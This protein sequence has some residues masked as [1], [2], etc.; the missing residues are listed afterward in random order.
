MKIIYPPPVGIG[1]TYQQNIGGGVVQWPPSPGSDY[2]GHNATQPWIA[3]IHGQECNELEMNSS[4]AQLYILSTIKTH[5]N[6]VI[7]C[8]GVDSAIKAGLKIS[9]ILLKYL[10]FWGQNR[11][12]TI[13]CVCQSVACVYSTWNILL[14]CQA[15]YFF[16]INND[17]VWPLKIFA[18]VDKFESPFSFRGHSI[19]TWS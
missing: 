7:F 15:Q 3:T 6:L 13:I 17:F 4:Q 9:A 10:Y 12:L 19:T 11:Q 8:F 1:L 2:T 5:L 18:D 14:W 16:H